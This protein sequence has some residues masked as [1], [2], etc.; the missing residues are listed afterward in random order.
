M[1]FKTIKSEGL[2]AISYLL[3]DDN[4]GEC[5]VI[6]PRRDV[7]VYLE[8]ARK[9]NVRI[10]HIFETHIHA[11][12]V[13]GSV[14]LAGLTG[15]K[16]HVGKSADY[17]FPAEQMPEGSELSFGDLRIQ[18]L[19]TPG[20]TPE[21]MSLLI[22]GG[23]GASKPW[24]V[25]TGDTLF[26]GEVGRPDLV[27]GGTEMT[28]ARQLYH[29][30]HEK[31][32][33]LGDEVEVYPGHGEG[34]PCGGNIG[35]RDST[36][37]G[38]ERLHNPKLQA[39]SEEAFVKAVLDGLPPAPSYYSRMKRV[40]ASGA[41]LLRCLPVVPPLGPKEFAG[42]MQH[43]NQIVV[44]AREI[45]AFGGAHID[46]ALNIALREEFPIWAGWMLSPEEHVLLVLT[47]EN[48]LETAV[49]HL[50]RIGI[51]S[52][53]G[54]LRKGMRGW[55]EAGLPFRTVPQMSVHDLKDVVMDAKRDG[56]QVLDVRRDDEWRRGRI[57]HAQHIF[58]ANLPGRANELDRRRPVAAYCGSGYRA[59]IAASVLERSGF[60]RVFNVPG[61]MKAWKAAGYPVEKPE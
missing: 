53:A 26:A 41:R 30:L 43:E 48:E 31:L 5:A 55:I 25:F 21:H 14:E 38:Y 6:D 42:K 59:S 7:D 56:W 61:S 1:I 32:L 12:Y 45:E 20:H 9:Q 27:G 60:E 15:A 37:I 51:D 47:H 58:A 57:P 2:A 29:S 28:L 40:N 46:G 44:D 4:A 23:Q 11:D 3:G 54:Y 8:V 35:D 49:R 22:S 34:S 17:Q 16:V 24:A 50:L 19:H 52:I 10:T 39:R 33:K 13:S 36:T 18:V